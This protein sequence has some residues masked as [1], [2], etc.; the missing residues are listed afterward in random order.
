[1]T[2]FTLPTCE[3]TLTLRPG[4]EGQVRFRFPAGEAAGLSVRVVAADPAHKRLTLS[5]ESLWGFYEMRK[6]AA[7]D[8]AHAWEPLRPGA[9]G[10]AQADLDVAAGERVSIDAE[11]AYS[12][13]LEL[14]R[15]AWQGPAAVLTFKETA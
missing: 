5:L 3:H 12:H 4:A 13:S 14:A 9:D 11:G 7:R 15:V 2:G 8:G 10:R 6:R 1:M